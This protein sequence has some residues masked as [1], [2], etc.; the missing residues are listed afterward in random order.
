MIHQPGE[1]Y[2]QFNDLLYRSRYAYQTVSLRDPDRL[3]SAHFLRQEHIII[4]PFSP[5]KFNSSVVL[6]WPLRP[7]RALGVNKMPAY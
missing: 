3:D 1:A 4:N 2:K 5:L 6:L 7:L